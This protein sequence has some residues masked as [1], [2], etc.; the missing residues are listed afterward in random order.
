[1]IRFIQDFFIKL[2]LEEDSKKKIIEEKE[3]INISSMKI[4]GSAYTKR[5]TLNPEGLFLED[6]LLKKME[7]EEL[8][9]QLAFQEPT[10]LQISVDYRLRA[11]TINDWKENPEKYWDYI[12]RKD[13]KIYDSDP[14]LQK[15]LE[16]TNPHNKSERLIYLEEKK[17][18]FP[19]KN[20]YE[21]LA[22]YHRLKKFPYEKDFIRRPYF[23]NGICQEDFNRIFFR[24]TFMKDFKKN[25]SPDF[26]KNYYHEFMEVFERAFSEASDIAFSEFVE[27][28]FRLDFREYERLKSQWQLELQQYEY[29]ENIKMEADVNKFFDI[30]ASF[31][32]TSGHTKRRYSYLKRNFLGV[33]F[34]CEMRAPLDVSKFIEKCIN[35]F[36]GFYTFLIYSICGGFILNNFIIFIDLFKY[37]SYSGIDLEYPECSIEKIKLKNSVSDKLLGEKFEINVIEKENNKDSNIIV[38]FLLFWFLFLSI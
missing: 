28:E 14:K 9:D 17:K 6:Q 27:K 33:Y 15:L 8:E 20:F 3:N 18:G 19:E 24:E 21:K 5:S 4:E 31:F 26:Y 29:W 23:Y 7:L 2:G 13:L 37:F 1:M 34:E 22:K 32:P 38:F 30:F 11:R 35:I 36:C 10:L 25:C 12:T 16:Y